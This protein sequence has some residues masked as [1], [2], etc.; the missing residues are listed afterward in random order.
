MLHPAMTSY[1]LQSVKPLN[2]HR[3]LLLFVNGERRIF[4]VNPYIK[5]SWMGELADEE[6]FRTV[7]IHPLLPD[8][9]MWPNEQDIAPHEL[10]QLST[11]T[12]E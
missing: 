3:L 9:V 2:N 4:D 7:R 12:K 11:T 1:E 5:G 10:Y 8:T 6:Y